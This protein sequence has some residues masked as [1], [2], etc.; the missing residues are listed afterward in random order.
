MFLYWDGYE[1]DGSDT[2][3]EIILP[4][5]VQIAEFA[6]CFLEIPLFT[7]TPNP[8]YTHYHGR[9]RKKMTKDELVSNLLSGD[10][11]NAIHITVNCQHP[12]LLTDELRSIVYAK[13][14][15]RKFN[16][17][18][19]NYPWPEEPIDYAKLENP[20]T[21][22]VIQDTFDRGGVT[23]TLFICKPTSKETGDITLSLNVGP[24]AFYEYAMFVVDYMQER[25]PSIKTDIDGGLN[26]C[27]CTF[28]ASLYAYEKI[29][30]PV[31]HSVKHT[32]KRLC[33]YGLV[34]CRS[35]YK[36]GWK[37]NEIANGFFPAIGYWHYDKNIGHMPF[38][39][40]LEL[41]EIVSN[42]DG[43][44]TA[45]QIFET[46]VDIILP[47]PHM[48][49]ENTEVTQILEQAISL[50]AHYATA[51]QE[52]REQIARGYRTGY[53]SFLV[54]DGANLNYIL[55]RKLCEGST[56]SCALF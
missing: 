13:S 10:Y 35:W 41:V 55:A 43:L 24:G 29:H 6:Q 54:V 20:C 19:D 4:E 42:S 45:S 31:K 30:L 5:N 15:K 2:D 11:K 9:K 1:I 16:E 21:A 38:S 17:D 32:L 27:G 25:F 49:Q 39:E 37:H 18:P 28:S 23:M 46:A 33:E 44:T 7:N 26:T 56:Q 3:F 51:N 47:P 22:P 53:M 36:N 8:E 14:E 52:R 40:Y 34:S 50:P 48:F 12:D